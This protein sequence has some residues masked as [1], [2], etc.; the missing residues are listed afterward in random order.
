MVEAIECITCEHN[1]MRDYGKNYDG[2]R[3]K[4][5]I[6]KKKIFTTVFCWE[7]IY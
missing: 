3:V 2:P 5:K 6:L 1:P 4:E 7:K